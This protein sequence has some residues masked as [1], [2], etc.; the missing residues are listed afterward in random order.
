[1]LPKVYIVSFRTREDRPPSKFIR[2]RSVNAGRNMG[3][4]PTH[5]HYLAC[6][7]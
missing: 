3:D 6:V 5:K 7:D 1:L 2:E 4:V